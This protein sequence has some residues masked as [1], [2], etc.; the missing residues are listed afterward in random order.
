MDHSPMNWGTP[1]HV[2][3]DQGNLALA[4]FLLEN[5][6]DVNSLNRKGGAPLAI[7]VEKG[8][9]DLAKLL[10]DHGADVNTNNR[11]IEWRYFV[12]DDGYYGTPLHLTVNYNYDT[13]FDMAKLFLEHGA[14]LK[15]PDL[16]GATPLHAA[17]GRC[18]LSTIKLLLENGALANVRN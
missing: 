9:L 15:G 14:D 2:A 17:A 7:A 4:K 3:V 10:L 12:F 11:P 8:D 5:K 18:S 1:L 16:S 6:A 13:C